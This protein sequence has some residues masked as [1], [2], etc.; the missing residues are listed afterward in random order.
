MAD[1]TVTVEVQFDGTSWTDISDRTTK[2]RIKYGTST[3]LDVLA[4]EVPFSE[5]SEKPIL[6]T[7]NKD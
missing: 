3:L 1:I 2:A 5:L 6:P 7:L 4:N